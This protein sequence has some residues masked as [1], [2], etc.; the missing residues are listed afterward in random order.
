M[1]TTAEHHE[2]QAVHRAFLGLGSNLGD[3]AANL[4]AAVDLMAER[5]IVVK[6]ASS[7]WETSP[8]P[9]DQPPFLNA[10]VEVETCLDPLPL[11]RVLQQIETDL[12]RRPTRRWGPRPID[13][14]IL[15]YDDLVVAT[16]ELVIPHPEAADRRF[17]LVP[18]SEIC[19]GPVPVL[20][21]TPAD[22]LTTATPLDMHPT[23]FRLST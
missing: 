1:T 9:A 14:D 13:L 17:V 8:I 21:L 22:L 4:L 20:A 19:P 12:G 5:G 16:P 2:P 18:L 3:R 10:A 23:P 6:R 7:V 15:F 11:L